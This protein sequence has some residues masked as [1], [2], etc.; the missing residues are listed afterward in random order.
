[1]LNT[2]LAFIL[3]FGAGFCVAVGLFIRSY[4]PPQPEDLE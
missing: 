4:E 3:G 1:M 2:W